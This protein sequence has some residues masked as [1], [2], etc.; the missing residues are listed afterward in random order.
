M[1]SINESS[2]LIKE[3][4]FT[5][6]KEEE[7]LEPL[8]TQNEEIDLSLL[9]YSSYDSLQDLKFENINQYTCDECTEI[10]KI[11]SSNKSKKTIIFK[12][13]NHGQKEINIRNYIV[14]SLKYNPNNWKC[15]DSDHFQK[16]SM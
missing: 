3:N 14:N 12:C 16:D 15:S 9:S 4:R 13:K 1:N 8:E 5:V 11:I 7:T 6:I 10:P 2:N